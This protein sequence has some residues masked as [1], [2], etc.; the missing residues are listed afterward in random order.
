MGQRLRWLERKAKRELPLEK[1]FI[2]PKSESEREHDL[3]PDEILTEVVLPPTAGLKVG[4]YEVRQKDAFDWPL[5]V[6][7]GRAEDGWRNCAIRAR[8]DGLC[9]SHAVAVGGGRASD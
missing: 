7:A 6:A 5:A 9:R 3:K 2:I 4:Y 1:F 8:G